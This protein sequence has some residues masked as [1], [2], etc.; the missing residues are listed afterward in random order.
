MKWIRLRN[1]GDVDIIKAINIMGA[2]VKECSDPIGLFGSGSKYA[3]AQAL[4]KNIAVKIYCNG[5]LYTMVG[6]TEEFRGKTFQM[7]AFKTSTGKVIKTP[8]A[9]DFGKEDWN[10]NFYILREFYS[11]LLDEGGEVHLVDGCD[12]GEEG[13][14]DVYLPYNVFQEQIDN[15]DKY[16]E[17]NP[18][19]TLKEGSG[20][21]YKKGVYVGT[22]PDLLLDMWDNSV[23]ITESRTMLLES[24][25]TRLSYNMQECDDSKIWE[26][27][28]NSKKSAEISLYLYSA[29]SE[30]ID[31]AFKAIHGNNYS[32]CPK[33]D[34]IVS[35]CIGDGLTPVLLSDQW[36]FGNLKLPNY[37][38]K[39]KDIGTRA[40]NAAEQVIIDKALKSIAFIT[41]GITFNITVIENPELA[42]YGD[43]NLLTGAIRLHPKNFTDYT[44][45]LDT[46]IHE[47]G[48]VITKA[49]DYDKNFVRF[50][51][52]KLA[53]LCE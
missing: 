7:V 27:F 4:R 46:L 47:I 28:F 10:D 49:S 24:A 19:G 14:I 41:D 6:V 44:E 29:Q 33:M 11:N 37:L 42:R 2:S 35:Q 23:K 22:I 53:K 16:F 18:T 3:L 38:N 9:E 43:A 21:V 45:L 32:I 40:L 30:V 12:T 15:L 8:I 26:L 36:S 1:K 31:T 20:R 52:M 51:T 34:M 39:L 13:Y 17:S 48:H 5:R 25:E 50:F